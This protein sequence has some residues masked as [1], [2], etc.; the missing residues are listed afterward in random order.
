MN[1]TAT[2]PAMT[3]SM[4]AETGTAAKR[5]VLDTNL[6]AKYAT[7]QY[8]QFPI[9]SMAVIHGRTLCAGDTGL[10]EFTGD[11]DNGS[12]ITAWFELPDLDLG[13]RQS[14]RLRYIYLSVEASGDLTV[15]VHTELGLEQTVTVPIT[16]PGQHKCRIPVSRNIYGGYWTI[17]V[18]NEDNGYDFSVDEIRVLP[19]V[20]A[21][22]NARP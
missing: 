9:N 1:I 21:H 19:V 14:K 22:G 10:F 6:Q 11:T 13:A 8:T 18:S 3:L 15:S 4:S 2:F 20:L 7:T 12:Q 5:I 17:K 16:E